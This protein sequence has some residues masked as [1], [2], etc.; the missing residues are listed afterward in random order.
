[1]TDRDGYGYGEQ[2]DLFQ[3]LLDDIRVLGPSGIER[4]AHGWDRH[5]AIHPNRRQAFD[6]ARQDALEKVRKEAWTS[7]QAEISEFTEG[8]G[9]TVAWKVEPGDVG[10]RAEEAALAA[11]L[12]VL[13][14][15][16][17]GEDDYRTLVRPMSEAIRWL[18]PD[19]EPD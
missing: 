2:A 9:S 13:A 1:M 12:A 8:R 7:A 6:K 18:L 3:R 5:V 17:L 4:I 19:E 16:R 15:D 10:H 11:G 14:R